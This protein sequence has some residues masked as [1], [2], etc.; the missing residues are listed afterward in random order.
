M[1]DDTGRVVAASVIVASLLLLV[2][3]GILALATLLWPI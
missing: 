1:K 2:I 3:L